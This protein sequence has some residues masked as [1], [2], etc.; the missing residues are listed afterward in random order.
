M[1][2]FEDMP[3]LPDLNPHYQATY[4]QGFLETLK[5]L[6]SQQASSQHLMGHLHLH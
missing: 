1:Q 6:K 2:D 5:R 3:A 4:A